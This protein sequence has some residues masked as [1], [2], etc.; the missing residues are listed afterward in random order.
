M[1]KRILV[2]VMLMLP[3]FGVAQDLKF[4]HI[5]I[6]EVFA[7]MP[8]TKEAQTKLE[9]SQSQMESK[10][11]SLTEEAMK[12][13]QE[14]QAKAN[15]MSEAEKEDAYAELQGYEER[16]TRYRENA[17]KEL[18]TKQMELLQPIEEKLRTIIEQVGKEK[19]L[20]YIFD[21]GM[22]VVHYISDKSVDVTPFV[23]EKLGIQ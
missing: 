12:R 17:A 11:A 19:G 10:L 1:V 2:A 18:Q 22:G 21:S 7:I 5:N 20:I 8:E 14:L 4:G 13:K 15:T 23:K 6:Q 3:M 16:I 9:A